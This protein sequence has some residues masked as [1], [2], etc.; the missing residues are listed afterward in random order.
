[1]NGSL[2]ARSDAAGSHV[3][4]VVRKLVRQQVDDSESVEE[5]DGVG[6]L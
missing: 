3:S 1:M 4:D 2:L 5:C 6:W